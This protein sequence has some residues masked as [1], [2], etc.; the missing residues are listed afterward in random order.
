VGDE[1]FIIS[2]IGDTGGPFS[3]ET[4]TVRI[5]ANT[6]QTINGVATNINIDSR[7]SATPAYKTAHMICV[8]TNTWAMTI[9][10][11]GPV[12]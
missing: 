2:Q 10:D 6:G 4:G 11:V 7:V 12:A 5:V 1:Y 3:G 8:D 9:S